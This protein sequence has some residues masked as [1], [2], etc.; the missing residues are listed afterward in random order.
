MSRRLRGGHP[1]GGFR[2]GSVLGDGLAKQ[3]ILVLRGTPA[4]VDEERDPVAR[5]IVCSL[6]QGTE[7]IGVEVGY[8]RNLV[9]EDR[10]AVG[11]GTVTLAERTAVLIAKATVLTP[12]DVD[13]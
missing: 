12:K 2:F 9:I 6:P 3:P 7:Q 11:D 5:G 10:R 13:G 1:P 4:T 8:T